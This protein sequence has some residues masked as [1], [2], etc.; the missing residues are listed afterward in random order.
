MNSA[1]SSGEPVENSSPSLLSPCVAS[2]LTVTLLG[3]VANGEKVDSDSTLQEKA[4]TTFCIV[5]L[6]RR[7]Q[8]LEKLLNEE[9]PR[10]Y[11][12]GVILQTVR[13][14][15]QLVAAGKG[16]ET[17]TTLLA[18]AALAGFLV[19]FK[20]INTFP[21]LR[22]PPMAAALRQYVHQWVESQGG[23]RFVLS[24]LNLVE[25]LAELI[26]TATEEYSK[27]VS[28]TASTESEALLLSALTDV[29]RYCIQV[30]ST[31]TPQEDFFLDRN[32][33]QSTMRHNYSVIV[34]SEKEMQNH[35]KVMRLLVV[36]RSTL[37]HRCAEDLQVS[38]SPLMVELL[39]FFDNLSST[40]IIPPD[41]RRDDVPRCRLSGLRLECGAGSSA[42]DD[43]VQQY[44]DAAIGNSVPTP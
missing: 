3:S 38:V 18:T 17:H 20:H 37:H 1:D 6:R 21:A 31:G 43:F 32:A 23:V 13:D 41:N 30:A 40:C 10:W 9:F 24:R 29:C 2:G 19:T 8:L 34:G 42:V 28:T 39:S 44:W 15:L 16:E 7:Q 35:E 25:D 33:M 12:I 36:A 4:I 14:V 27:A 26:R 5:H 22:S 11:E